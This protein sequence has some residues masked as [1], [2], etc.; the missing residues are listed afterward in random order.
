MSKKILIYSQYSVHCK[1]I[2]DRISSMSLFDDVHKI[3]IDNRKVRKQV[4]KSSILKLEC[5]PCIL[6]L[7][8]DGVVEK[9]DGSYAFEWVDF[10]I[11]ENAVSNNE[12]N[13]SEKEIESKPLKKDKVNKKSMSEEVSMTTS[14][15]DLDE[16]AEEIDINN[17][18]I[19]SIDI[20]KPLKSIITN[21]GNYELISD[22]GGNNENGNEKNI[23]KG[24]KSNTQ[25]K[26]SDIISIAQAMQKD[27][28]NINTD[29]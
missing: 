19:D 25:S 14:I 12:S 9:Y 4:L 1:K 17:N 22:F 15:N 18:N 20:K 27:R 13:E 21:S 10:I 11:S 2:I 3:C 23:S 16:D 8:P 7:Y 24:I 28:D 6:L 29:K 5:V 26:G